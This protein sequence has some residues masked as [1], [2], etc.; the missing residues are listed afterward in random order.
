[1]SYRYQA[2]YRNDPPSQAQAQAP[3]QPMPQAVSLMLAM[4]V[5]FVIVS[6]VVL[7]AGRIPFT[8]T[9]VALDGPTYLDYFPA[10]D[11]LLGSYGYTLEGKVHIPID[12][13]IDLIVERGLPALETTTPAATPTP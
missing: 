1:M 3:V 4:L 12:Q 7:L 8:P 2:P 13:A 5:V 9:V 10:Q 11:E 6:L